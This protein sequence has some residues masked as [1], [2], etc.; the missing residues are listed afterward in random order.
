[1]S[2][3]CHIRG[4]WIVE[5]GTPNVRGSEIARAQQYRHDTIICHLEPSELHGTVEKI[6]P[7]LEGQATSP[8][9]QLDGKELGKDFWA[10]E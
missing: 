6:I 5:A 3:D 10:P 9:C 4:T 8:I 7:L 2:E 1:M